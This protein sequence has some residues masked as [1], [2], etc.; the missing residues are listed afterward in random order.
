MGKQLSCAEVLALI[1]HAAPFRFVDELLDLTELSARG[2]YRFRPDEDFY[3]GHFPGNPVTPGVVL[4]ET[5]AQVGVVA[6]GIYLYA[7]ENEPAEIE[8][9]LIVFA[10]AE[11][12][13]L[14]PVRPGDEVTVRS[15]KIFFRRKQ[16]RSR[17]ELRLEG[18]A[19]AAS[20]IISGVGVEK[21]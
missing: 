8:R 15:E 19:L 17:V 20:A 14:R 12:S 13:F 4:L 21:P 10:D 18:G 1:P 6:H 9:N 3:R 2:R 16:L 7:L 11:V 5:M